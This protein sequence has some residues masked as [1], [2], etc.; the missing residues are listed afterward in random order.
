[1]PGKG[2]IFTMIGGTV[3][4]GPPV[5]ACVVFAQELGIIADAIKSPAGKKTRNLE[6]KLF[7]F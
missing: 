5:G 7:I 3:S 1:M 4:F 6:S 2:L